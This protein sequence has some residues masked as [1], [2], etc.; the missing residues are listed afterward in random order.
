MV[1]FDFCGRRRFAF[2]SSR[3]HLHRGGR[4]A[5]TDVIGGAFGAAAGSW[6]AAQ[7]FADLPSDA[8]VEA[9]PHGCLAAWECALWRRG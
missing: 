9:Y 2:A 5:A 7:T 6:A 1:V 3:D 4:N 8:E